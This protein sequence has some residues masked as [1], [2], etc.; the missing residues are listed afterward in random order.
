[1]REY[2]HLIMSAY[3]HMITRA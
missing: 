1:M 2:K 3:N